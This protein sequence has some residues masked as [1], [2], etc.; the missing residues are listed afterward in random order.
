MKTTFALLLALL[1]STVGYAA[2]NCPPNLLSATPTS[3]YTVQSNTAEVRDNLTGLVWQ[4]CP[5]GQSWS[6]TACSGSMSN[7]TWP[8]A[9][10]EANT[11]VSSAGF[12]WRLPNAKEALSLMEW[13]CTTPSI[14]VT[15]FPTTDIEFYWTSTSDASLLTSTSA[16]A[17]TYT[18]TTTKQTG[19]F[20]KTSLMAV[21]LVR[22]SQ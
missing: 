17:V 6:G 18:P 13:A 11:A 2:Q 4:R 8:L 9:L 20:V 7:F 21:R 16:W 1:V 12:A 15:A 5:I 3:R 19:L 14:N 10:V 22:S